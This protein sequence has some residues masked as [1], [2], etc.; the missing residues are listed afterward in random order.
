M[1]KQWISGCL[2]VLFLAV[3]LPTVPPRTVSAADKPVVLCTTFPIYQITRN[4][5]R[6]RTGIDVQLM[7]P[8]Q[9]G[10]PHDYALTPQD[11]RKL[12]RADILVING[13]G[14]EE[15]L[16]TPMAKADAR[17][18]II[19]SSAGIGEIIA[20]TEVHDDHDRDAHHHHHGGAN[21]HLFVSPRLAARIAMRIADGLSKADPEGAEGYSRNARAYAEAMTRLAAEMAA[22]GKRLGNNRIVQPHG[23]FDY[24][25]RDMGLEIVAVTQAEGQEPSAAEMLA[26]V[27]T[28]REKKAGA[29]FTEPQY[30]DKVGGTLANETGIPVAVLDPAATGPENAPLDY[31]ETTM[32]NNLRTLE[33]TLGLK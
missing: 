13:L 9:L 12:N 10:C 33:M 15:F 14:M 6:G 25:A 20:Y 27:K 29:I 7:L 4:I 5:T 21:P 28:I 32:R 22:L 1:G 19:D 8:S 26:L 2:L 24:L 31:Y 16:G 11:L 3:A 30:S 17:L 23:V 18:G